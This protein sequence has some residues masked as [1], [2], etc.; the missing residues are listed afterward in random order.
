[1]AFD[2]KGNLFVANWSA[3]TV[4][5]IGADGE[6]TV[7]AENLSGPAGLAIDKDDA[8]YVASYSSDLIYRFTA[9]GAQS[10]HVTGLATPAGLSFDQKGRL[11][12]ANR[13]TNQVLAVMENGTLQPVAGGLRTPVGAVQRRDGTLVVANING[14]ITILAPDGERRE[15]NDVFSRPG[16]GVALTADDRVFVVDYGGTTVR[17]IRTDGSTDVVA[18]GLRSPVGLTVAP[19]G[20]LLVATWGDDTAYRIRA[21]R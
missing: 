7:F 18:D 14:G 15:I 1:M 8:V 16:P 6:R 13:A 10:V 21:A 5:R 11:L 12:I 3:G 2:S 20:D 9:A 4:D 19:D 17:E